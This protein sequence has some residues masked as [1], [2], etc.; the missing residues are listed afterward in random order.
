MDRAISFRIMGVKNFSTLYTKATVLFKL[1]RM[2][3]AK[4]VMDEAIP[5]GAMSEVHFYGRTLFNMKQSQEAMK[6]F[7]GNYD[8]YPN[9]YTTNVGLGRAWSALGEYKKAHRYMKAAL[10][11]A[12]DEVNKNNVGND[13]KAGRR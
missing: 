12:P 11:Q 2:E 8:K 13:P 9:V 4:K 1:N 7:K 10:P 6:I 5:L 3:E